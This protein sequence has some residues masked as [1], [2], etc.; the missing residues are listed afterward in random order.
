MSARADQIF[1]GPLKLRFDPLPFRTHQCGALYYVSSCSSLPGPGWGVWTSRLAKQGPP[2]CIPLQLFFLYPLSLG[3][4]FPSPVQASLDRP[5][6]SLFPVSPITKHH[7]LV[8]I[9]PGGATPEPCFNR[10]ARNPHPHHPP[11]PCIAP[12]AEIDNSTFAMLE[13]AGFILPLFDPSQKDPHR[14]HT[15]NIVKNIL[16]F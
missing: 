13:I 15:P 9:A 3:G 7:V 5:Q 6:E 2:R 12:L 8:V 11:L 10:S 4:A 16:Q 14:C 1:S